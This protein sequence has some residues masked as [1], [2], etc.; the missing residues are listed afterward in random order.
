MTLIRRSDRNWPIPSLIDNL[1]SRD[2]M[3]WSNTNYSTTN[4]TLPAVNIKETDDDYQIEVA[5]PGMDKKDFK[6]LNQLDLNSRQSDAEIGKKCRISKQVVNYRIKKLIEEGII[7]GFYPQINTLKLG[8]A[9]H[10]VYLKFKSLPNVVEKEMWSYLTKQHS[11]VWII[12]CSGKWDF[13]I[14]IASKN[15]EEFNQT[16]DDFMNK[17]SKYVSERAI[18]VFNKATLHH[19]KWLINSQEE[20]HWLFGALFHSDPNPCSVFL[21]FYTH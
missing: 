7:N 9:A 5:A 11:I 16:L 8:Y 13:I 14:G 1:F 2:L 10:K 18:S 15:I 20:I 21:S 6:I 12:S 3:D 19:R 4:T 17:Y